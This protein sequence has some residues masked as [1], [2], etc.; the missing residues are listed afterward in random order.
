MT[1]QC[2]RNVVCL[3][4]PRPESGPESPLGIRSPAPGAGRSHTEPGTRGSS[5]RGSSSRSARHRW[6]PLSLSG[7]RLDTGHTGA[8]PRAPRQ[9]EGGEPVRFRTPPGEAKERRGGTSPG[10]AGCLESREENS[11][12]DGHLWSAYMAQDRFRSEFWKPRSCVPRFALNRAE[13]AFPPDPVKLVEE[14]TRFGRCSPP[15]RVRLRALW[16]APQGQGS[17]C[18]PGVGTAGWPAGAGPFSSRWT[19]GSLGA[20]LAHQRG[21]Q[22]PRRAGAPLTQRRSEGLARDGVGRGA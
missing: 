15:S 8:G 20:N 16:W 5:S 3:S 10:A 7:G 17:Q 4:S 1:L 14:P 12:S 13:V 22:V 19:A 21:R 18:R 9:G 2:S 11:S 6:L